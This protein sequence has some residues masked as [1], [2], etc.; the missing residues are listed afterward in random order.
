[1]SCNILKDIQHNSQ[2]GHYFSFQLQIATA[3]F[4][5]PAECMYDIFIL[6][7]NIE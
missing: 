2:R 4:P 1:M 7:N 3:L 6:Y 5:C